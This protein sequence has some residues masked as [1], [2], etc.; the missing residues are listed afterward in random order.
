MAILIRSQGS[1]KWVTV[2][3]VTYRQE[4]ELQKLLADAP[5]L[6]PVDEI[7]PGAAPFV[8]AVR[9]FGLPGSGH[10]DLLVFTSDG[11]VAVIECKLAAN[12]ESKRQVIG[13]ILEYGAYLWGMSYD[14]VDSRVQARTGKP[15]VALVAE[16]VGDQEWDE[17]GFRQ[18]VEQALAE[19]S[20]SLVIAVDEVNEEMNKTIAFLNGCG[21]PAFSFH[22]L[23][24]HRFN[25]QGIEIMV[26]RLH[27]APLQKGG[28]QPRKQ[29]TEERFFA[30]VQENR[31]AEM[32]VIWQLYDLSREIADRVWFGNG[33]KT[34]SFT[35]HYLVDSRT[36][37]V[38]TV[39]TTGSLILNYGWLNEV[40]EPAQVEQFH[41]RIRA[42]PSFRSLP[43]AA[44]K[45]PSLKI[46]RAFVG[47]TGALEEFVE[48]VKEL[49]RGI[50]G[51][52]T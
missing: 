24:M 28:E 33:A 9:E 30:V 23:E 49:G 32:P 14:E 5:S 15:L 21:R 22:A 10:T 47:Q 50:R 37:S 2:E 13:Q 7:Q 38:F 6:I 19:G 11:G 34:G 1:D 16:A 20:F 31:P 40:V 52:K 43:M 25:A 8:A 18:G 27:G 26:P 46:A 44:A 42:I 39:S 3:V 48:A 17:K 4:A 51:A 29:W 12:A 41:R 36:A 35:F 45:W